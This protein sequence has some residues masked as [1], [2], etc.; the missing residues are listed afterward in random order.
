VA[1]R[2]PGVTVLG[3]V[4]DHAGRP[5]LGVAFGETAPT[6]TLYVFDPTTAALLGE[7]ELDHGTPAPTGWA[8]YLS[9]GV[10]DSL[11]ATPTGSAPPAPAVSVTCP[12]GPDQPCR[13]AGG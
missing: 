10:V 9:S 1:G 12:A 6:G 5:G 8:V 4:T 13:F 3:T 11:S 7:E 2:I